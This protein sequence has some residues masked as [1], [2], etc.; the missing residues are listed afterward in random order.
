MICPLCRRR[1][2]ETMGRMDSYPKAA[3]ERQIAKAALLSGHNVAKRTTCPC[4][5][6]F[7]VVSQ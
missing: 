3:M 4:V 5:S 6:I 7:L 1:V 2:Q